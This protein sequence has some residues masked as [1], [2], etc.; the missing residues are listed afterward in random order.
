MKAINV[1][2]PFD[3]MSCGQIALERA[4][5][6]I[7]AY[8]ASEIDKYAIKVTQ[9]NYPNTIQLGDA[10]KWREWDL[11][12]IDLI[13]AGSPCQ[14]FSFA[15][16][17]LAF[18]DPRSKL[19]F[20]FIDMLKY[21]KPKYFLLENVVMSKESNDVISSVLG[22]LYPECV[23]QRDMFKAGRL[24]PIQ[25]NSALVSAQNRQR[26]YWTNIP[27]VKQP[28]DR[29]I[30]LEDIL[31]C[32]QALRSKSQTIPAT[33]YK[34]NVKSMVKRGKKGLLVRHVM[35]TERRTE[36]AKKQR[37][38]NMKKGRDFSPRR[39]KEL[40]PQTDSKSNC[41]TTS[42]TKEHIL[43]KVPAIKQHGELIYKPHKSQCLD[44]NYFKGPDNHGQRTGCIEIGTAEGINGFE[45]M[46]R[47]YD[48][49][50]KHPTLTAITGGNQ[51]KKIAVDACH[52]RKLTCIE[53]E[54][55]QTVPD[56]YTNHVSNSQRYKML[57]N[58]W[59]VDVIVHVLGNTKWN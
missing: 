2:S 28:E 21:V 33:I 36:D 29:G 55:L 59:T 47:V 40:V 41:L 46:S 1:L 43:V 57:G 14:G 37:K 39:A 9:A 17:Q 49:K 10:T 20:T 48:T 15:G 8:Y 31:G 38:E 5:I 19:F 50:G 23:T 35:L 13:L 6:P 34:E 54:R 22:E 52:W 56:N 4:G 44:A 27:G 25:I 30:L 7:K 24:E 26:L 45:H 58:G 18:D 3:G 53:C 51:E 11:P 42:L 12:E 32:G 16:K